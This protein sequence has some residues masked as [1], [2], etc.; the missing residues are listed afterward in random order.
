MTVFSTSEKKREEALKVLKADHFI[1]SK[2]EEQMKV[3]E[4][5]K[6]EVVCTC[7]MQR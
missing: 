6:L 3:R 2:D 4:A 7:V 5:Y 1:V